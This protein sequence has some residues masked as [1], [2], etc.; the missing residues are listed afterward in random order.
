M[1][2]PGVFNFFDQYQSNSLPCPS[3]VFV[4][5]EQEM[6]KLKS[7][8]DFYSDT[9]TRIVNLVGSPGFGKSTLAIHLGNYMVKQGILV[10]YVNMA[11]YHEEQDM[12][13]ILSE[14]IL[15]AVGDEHCRTI[16]SFEALLRWLRMMYWNS[17][18]IIDDCDDLLQSKKESFFTTVQTMVEQTLRVKILL[19]S[20]E[21]STRLE[22]LERFPVYELSSHAACELLEK[23]LPSNTN[24][25]KIEIEEIARLTGNVPLALK[26]IG[27][28][29][30]SPNPPSPS[31][32]I[33]E[34][35]S[36]PIPLLSHEEIP[37]SDRI[38]VS[39]SL[40]YRYLSPEMQNIGQYLASF[41]GSFDRNAAHEILAGNQVDFIFPIALSFS[42]PNNSAIIR[43]MNYLVSRSLIEFNSQTQRYKFHRLI[44]EFFKEMRRKSTGIGTYFIPKFQVYYS[45]LLSKTVRYFEEDYKKSLHS[46]YMERHNYQSLLDCLR[47]KEHKLVPFIRMMIAIS[48][49]L[50]NSRLLNFY[51]SESDIIH[52]LQSA[53]DYIDTSELLLTFF[54]TQRI[55]EMSYDT[56]R[57]IYVTLVYEVARIEKNLL[58][59]EKARVAYEQR[60]HLI[61]FVMSSA[62]GRVNDHTMIRLLAKLNDELEYR[63]EAKEYHISSLLH[64][65]D[66]DS[67]FK[68]HVHLKRGEMVRDCSYRSIGM[69]YHSLGDYKQ[70]AVFFELSY[71]TEKNAGMEKVLL[72]Y[73]MIRVYT[74]LERVNKVKIYAQE[75]G[76]LIGDDLVSTL[77]V[78]NSRSK[79]LVIIRNLKM[80]NQ[81]AVASIL[82]NKL[83]EIIT[84][85][86]GEARSCFQAEGTLQMME[87]YYQLRN[88]SM[89]IQLGQALLSNWKLCTG[90]QANIDQSVETRARILTGKAKFNSGYFSQGM[91]ELENLITSMSLETFNQNEISDICWYLIPRRRYVMTCYPWVLSIP[92]EIVKVVLYLIF[93]IPLDPYS[94]V[95]PVYSSP[96]PSKSTYPEINMFT[97]SKDV[98]TLKLSEV[99]FLQVHSAF[100][101]K[102]KGFF[103][104]NITWAWSVASDL[105]R[106]FFQFTL[107]RF[108]VNTLSV[109]IRIHYFF[110]NVFS[111]IMIIMIMPFLFISIP[112]AIWGFLLLRLM[113]RFPFLLFPATISLVKFIFKVQ[114]VFSRY[115]IL[116]CARIYFYILAG[117][118]LY[119]WMS[120]RGLIDAYFS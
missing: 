52:P 14:K 83:V 81:Q 40:S 51:F 86:E 77:E 98:G 87:Y 53:L 15:T 32:I 69:A 93:V 29:L 50:L 94:S 67:I 82:E 113:L 75:L 46:L 59:I 117:F 116:P 5:R 26:I 35:K 34:L 102:A 73:D 61:Q 42:P 22:Y 19:T 99:G 18:V 114:I 27:A 64:L 31:V 89:V 11:E 80:I 44:Q 76:E 92:A 107:V 55:K 8:L 79:L 88:K 9:D 6:S 65:V 13:T 90:L 24:L 28:L 97:S 108:V 10:H 63:E 12:R 33:S 21:L 109:L 85:I 43:T 118:D 62:N 60:K 115:I 78:Y 16:F 120:A 68:C 39:I 74:S 112:L 95:S 111:T 105:T 3:K 54:R 36:H 56:F 20:R 38:N 25:L 106:F 30:S 103:N 70:S 110:S 71:E 96:L 4:G 58:G 91:D 17:V 49:A 84:D 7:L 37:H 1:Y 2:H 100:S 41:P 45:S 72:V 66:D 47:K 119:N 57:H 48:Q 101:S 104:E 23:K